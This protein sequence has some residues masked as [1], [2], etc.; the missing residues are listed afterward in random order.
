MIIN[1]IDNKKKKFFIIFIIVI[2]LFLIT[3]LAVK[4]GQEKRK[5]QHLQ[6]E[7]ARVKQYTSLQ[8]FKN[9]EE[10]ALY[11]NCTL[12]RQEEVQNSNINYNVYM[13]LPEEVCANKAE[14]RTFFENLIQYSAHALDYKNFCII[15][16]KNNTKVI[17]ECNNDGKTVNAYSIDGI[18]NYFEKQQNIENMNN[19]KQIKSINIE[20]TSPQ[21]K[22]IISNNWSTNN[23]SLGT[24][25]S[26]YRNYDVYFDEGY[27]V[28]KVDGKVFNIVFTS[29]YSDSVVSNL[30]ATS[31][32]DEIKNALGEPQFENGDLIGYKSND[33]Y[34]FF[35][36]SQISVY[37][38]EKYDKNEITPIIE[39][40]KS[41]MDSKAFIEEL[42]STWKDYDV[43]T[44]NQNSE[45]LQ[46]TLKGILVKF[47]SSS[48]KGLLVYNNYEGNVLQN[49]TIANMAETEQSLPD[50]VFFENEDL[51]FKAEQE[52][53]N[54][55]D[56]TTSNNN[57]SSKIV[58]NTSNSFKIYKSK[59]SNDS[60]FYK[61]RFI[62]INEQY[63]NS[64]LREVIS[65]GIWADDNNFVYSV[66]NRGIYVYNAQ[67]RTYKTIKTGTDTFRIIGLENN[68]LYYDNETL[69]INL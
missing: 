37:R 17:V 35:G 13:K 20:I 53:V 16:E 64:E 48:Q 66:K 36:K 11:L 51:V 15:D 23:V 69:K 42:K 49:L 19:L 67:T 65:Y 46:Y 57:Y 50:F 28:R 3:I 68:I 2:L 41:N 39:K 18:S 58:L 52:R 8:E 38:K 6:E 1:K 44:Y 32:K 10:V 43:F 56:D 4:L 25:E 45:K 34:V 26:T 24:L 47:D 33:I 54:T 12:I 63:P 29:K 30:K 22:Q 59:L 9:M 40:Y 60:E 14:N 31:S 61:I 55:L 21:L 27:Q 62:S 7:T 5:Q